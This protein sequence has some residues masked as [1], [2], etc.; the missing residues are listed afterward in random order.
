ML[1][2]LQVAASAIL[3]WLASA[4]T[5]I[6]AENPTEFMVDC[7]GTFNLC[8]YIDRR[9]KAPLIPRQFERAFN[10]SEEMAGVRVN[11]RYGFI[12]RTGKLLIAARFD[13]V[14]AFYQGHAE[15]LVG[16]KAGVIDRQGKLV[17]EPRFARAIPFTQDVVLVSTKGGRTLY[18]QGHEQ[19]PNM[20]EDLFLSPSAFA[21][22]SL[23]SG[24]LTDKRYSLRRFDMEPSGLIW[25]S[26]DGRRFGLLRA[27]GTWQVEP[28]FSQVQPLSD[29]RAI[30]CTPD[31]SAAKPKP[32]KLSCGAVDPVGAVVIPLKSWHLSY[33]L[34][35]WGLASE[36]GK[37]GLIDKSGNIV[38]GRLFDDAERAETGDVSKVLLDGKWVG[39]DR[40]G[41]IVANPEDGTVIAACPS[42][43]KL[44]RQS[45]RVQVVG[46]D[47]RPS[48]AYLL[49]DTYNKLECDRPS[50]VSL[51]GK[52]GLVGVDGRLLIDPP[53]FDDLYGFQRQHAG[54]KVDGKWGVIDENGDY[55]ISP[56]FDSLQNSGSGLYAVAEAGRRFWVDSSGKEQPK[57]LSHI[58]RARWLKCGPDGAKIKAETKAGETTWGIVD[59]SG[60]VIV[61]PEHRAIHCFQNGVAWVPDDSKR[62]WCAVG[63]DGMPREYPPCMAYRYPYALADAGWEKFSDDPYE[64]SVLVTR[65]ML[66]FGIGTRAEP[67]KTISEFSRSLIAR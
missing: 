59:A 31:L 4:P 22:F 30:V 60:R 46:R 29:E 67:P 7:G 17:I 49:D 14:G 16:S 54:V 10:F 3:I 34:N 33:W 58:D 28:Q 26:E 12:D 32:G 36:G 62:Q 50:A 48:V 47:D 2:A 13:L 61:A 35:G 23:R 52:W 41:H 39:I 53:S 37:K 20:V 66:E 63:P 40:H 15:V 8:G 65:A 21:L 55:A 5:S 18:A 42:G 44:I 24:P 43:V 6:A 9:T 45:G 56:R 1:G 64:N 19:L 25:A 51:G 27:D 11:G 38:G 57:S